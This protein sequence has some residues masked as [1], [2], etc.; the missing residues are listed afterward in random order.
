MKNDPVKLGE[1]TAKIR[2]SIERNKKLIT[3]YEIIIPIIETYEGK[4]VTMRIKTAILG[5]LPEEFR[6]WYF[7]EYN[8][9]RLRFSWANPNSNQWESN[10]PQ[11]QEFRVY[12]GSNEYLQKETIQNIKEGLRWSKK[13]VRDFENINVWELVK[14]IGEWNDALD[15]LRKLYDKASTLYIS[16]FFTI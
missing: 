3:I 14:L 2:E 10:N 12:L 1:V 4:K 15:V 8:N 5:K 16:E 11:A 6:V 7:N 9:Y 13:Y